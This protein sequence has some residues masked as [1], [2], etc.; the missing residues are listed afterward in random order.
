MSRAS[1]VL[2]HFFFSNDCN[3]ESAI[4]TVATAR[5]VALFVD[6]STQFHILRE[7]LLLLSR[8]N[9]LAA[10]LATKSLRLRDGCYYSTCSVTVSLLAVPSTRNLHNTRAAGT[11][12]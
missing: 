2:L 4:F 1:C 8:S 7:Q 11:S 6:L 5:L 12:V 9:T 10:S 3:F